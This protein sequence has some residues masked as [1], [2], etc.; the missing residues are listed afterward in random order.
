[1]TIGNQTQSF[2]ASSS[3]TQCG[4]GT[5]LSQPEFSILILQNT[6][7]QTDVQNA[8]IRN[9]GGKFSFIGVTYVIFTS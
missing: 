5:P 4:S 3:S 8:V 9:E 2:N 6:A 7:N 1:M